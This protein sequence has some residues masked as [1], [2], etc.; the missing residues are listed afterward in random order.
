MASFIA[1]QS[2]AM[3]RYLAKKREKQ[4]KSMNYPKKNQKKA[5]GTKKK[6]KKPMSAGKKMGGM[7]Y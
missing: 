3:Q 4:M 1:C 5:K 2:L 7:G 6:T